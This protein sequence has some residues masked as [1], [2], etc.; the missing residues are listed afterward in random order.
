MH[1]L[2]ARAEFRGKR[3]TKNLR[4]FAF[5]EVL[6]GLLPSTNRSFC[7]FLGLFF[8]HDAARS[9]F[10]PLELSLDK[11]QGLLLSVSRFS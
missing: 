5:P 10:S 1:G 7:R 3:A 9:T 2:S 8:D 11:E 6:F 4:K